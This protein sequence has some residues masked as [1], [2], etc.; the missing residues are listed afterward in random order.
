M[1]INNVKDRKEFRV[2]LTIFVLAFIA[3]VIYWILL[4]KNYFFYNNP[5]ADVIYYQEWAKEIV[6]GNWIGNKTFYGLPLYP[7]FLS[8]LYVFCLGN[9][10]FIRLI[11]ILLGCF[12]C[13][14]VY[15]V[16]KKIFDTPIGLTA[17][18]LCAF[19]FVLIF[20]DWF[21]MPVTLL[22]TLSLGIVYFLIDKEQ[23]SL[24]KN[25]L[26]LG[27][28]I[29]LAVLGD[30]KFMIFLAILTLYYL[31]KKENIRKLGLLILGVFLIVGSVSLRNRIVGGS[32]VLVTSQTGLSFFVGNN[33]DSNGFYI[34]PTF[35]RPSHDGQDEDQKV[36]A[37]ALAGR[38]LKD[39][40]VSKFWVNHTLGIIKEYPKEY[41]F[42]LLKKINAFFTDSSL[43][44]DLDMIFQSNWKEKYDFNPFFIIFPL[45]LV[46]IYLSLRFKKN[47]VPIDLIILSQ[48][49][50]TLL[51][52]LNNR[53]RA[54][55]L[56][57]LIVYETFCLFWLLGKLKERKFGALFVIVAL[58][59]IFSLIFIPQNMSLREAEIM[60]DAKAAPIYLKQNDIAKAKESCLK[61][62]RDYPDDTNTLF[63]LGN[64]YFQER[65]V[66]KA[67]EAYR[68]VLELNPYQVDA[69]YNLAFTYELEA[70][71]DLAK[72]NYEWL[73][74]INDSA[75]DGHYRLAEIFKKEG[76]CEKANYHYRKI[77]EYEVFLKDEIEEML[78]PCPN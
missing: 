1:K 55:I 4:K 47:C 28:L 65:N 54:T 18:L 77:L 64:I 75:V 23:L 13:L 8:V 9:F 60:K 40:E 68:Q 38:E 10:F 61:V 48:F 76:N 16:S 6:A 17:G 62:L 44:Y 30:G 19:N 7:Y 20:Y 11:H 35:I 63:N 42:V 46:G 67:Q 29:G 3:R 72:K 78:L 24:K 57:F 36:V 69:V 14:L 41:L 5:S 49:V 53:H 37:Q 25:W 58:L 51:F 34:N 21:M 12:N 59:I 50:F 70:N 43:S 45:A 31:V 26:Y 39:N 27:I 66:K 32:W 22:I 15:K 56:P 2:V 33:L 71:F 73:V 74:E 52:F